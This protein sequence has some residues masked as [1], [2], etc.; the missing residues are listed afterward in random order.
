MFF[1]IIRHFCFQKVLLCFPRAH[2]HPENEHEKSPPGS[3]PSVG[4]VTGWAVD[5]PAKLG[6]VIPDSCHPA[7]LLQMS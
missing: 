7:A 6:S 2:Y 1:G 5:Y 4:K 3:D